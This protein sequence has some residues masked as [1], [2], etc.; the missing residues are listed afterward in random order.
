MIPSW[1]KLMKDSE[2]WLFRQSPMGCN[3]RAK[4]I[5]TCRARCGYSGNGQ[6][7][8]TIVALT[9]NTTSMY[10]SGGGGT[11]GAGGHANVASATQALLSAAQVQLGAFTRPSES[12]LPPPGWVRFHLLSRSGGRCEDVPAESF[13]GRVSHELMPVIRGDAVRYQ[14]HRVVIFAVKLHSTP[15][16]A[17]ASAAPGSSIFA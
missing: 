7:Y 9:D 14:C 16:R 17:D 4:T 5:L 12:D 3:P 10:A 2:T 13:W 11:L 1:L 15:G 6:F 8:A